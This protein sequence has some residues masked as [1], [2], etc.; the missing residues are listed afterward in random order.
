MLCCAFRAIFL[1]VMSLSIARASISGVTN[2]RP[3]FEI[4][5][6]VSNTARANERLRVTHE[7]VR[8]ASLALVLK[9]DLHVLCEETET[10]S[11]KVVAFKTS[12]SHPYKG[13][14]VT[15][16]SMY[17]QI[18]WNMEASG[19]RASWEEDGEGGE[20]GGGHK[21]GRA[22]GSAPLARAFWWF[23]ASADGSMSLV[24]VSG[25]LRRIRVPGA[26]DL[27]FDA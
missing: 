26:T 24:R 27:N 9:A 6:A 7:G 22:C 11:R 15:A 23:A 25:K 19:L 14:S 20:G 13:Y 10:E 1:I 3:R 21:T 5:R 2:S 4:P 18:I 8:T 12:R 16:L 17:S